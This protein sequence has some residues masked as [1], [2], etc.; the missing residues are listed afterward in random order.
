MSLGAVGLA[1][2]LLQMLRGETPAEEGVLRN[3]PCT[4]VQLGRAPQRFLKF[5][6]QVEKHT[7]AALKLCKW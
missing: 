6:R 4:P 7:G 1:G 5:A 3:H 2:S